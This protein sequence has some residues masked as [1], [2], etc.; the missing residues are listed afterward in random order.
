[1]SVEK[2]TRVSAE[3]PS[4]GLPGQNGVHVIVPIFP[5]GDPRNEGG[6]AGLP[7]DYEVIFTF[8]RPGYPLQPEKSFVSADQLEGDSHLGVLSRFRI[9]ANVE[10][11]LLDFQGQPNSKKYLGKVVVKCHANNIKDAHDR[12]FRALM[13]VLSNFALR[14]DVPLTI[15]QTDVKELR[16]GVL[17]IANRNPDREVSIRGQFMINLPPELRSYG[18]IY[19]EAITT[20]SLPYQFLCFFRLIESMQARRTRLSR[21]AVRQG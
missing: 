3:L 10:G 2:A 1:M 18:A 4:M 6:P 11:E 15:Y 5:Q 17:Q 21:D 12:C 8:T 14:W 19:R 16:N 20:E 9:T 7:G 13:P